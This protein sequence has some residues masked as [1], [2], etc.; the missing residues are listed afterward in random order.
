MVLELDRGIKVPAAVLDNNE[1]L[2]PAQAK[3]KDLV[4][5]E[6]AEDIIE[7]QEQPA[8]NEP[9]AKRSDISEAAWQEAQ[10]KADERYRAM[11]GDAAYNRASMQ[12]AQEAMR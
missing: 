7:A 9:S 2:A 3:A 11:F 5:A 4:A 6:F 8:A 10:R 12:A 1:P